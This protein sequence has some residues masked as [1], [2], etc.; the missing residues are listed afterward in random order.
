MRYFGA[1]ILAICLNGF[2]GQPAHA[3]KRVALVI[4]NANYQNVG[5]LANSA[6]DAATLAAT[7]K[8]A[9]FDVVTLRTDLTATEMRR[10]LR[11]F[12]DKARDSDIAVIYYAGH[13][14][15]VDGMNYLIP[16]DA[17]L[18]R[19]TDVYDEAFPLDRLLVAIEPAKHLRLVIL[20]ACRDNPFA[21]TMKRT[22]AMRSI[23]QGL[24]KVE[25]NSPNTLIA[26]AAK[27]GSTA[28]DGDS[29]NNGP[30]AVA[31]SNHLTTPGLDVRKAFGFVRDDVLKATSN[32]QE[33]FIYGSLGG[34]DVPL[35]PAPV[36]PAASPPSA[37]DVNEAI[38]RDYVLAERVGT[39][40]AWDLFLATYPDGFYSKLAQAQRNKLD[41]EDKARAATGE[42]A[43]LAADGAHIAEQAKAAVEAK[44]AEEARV[45]AEQTKA[46]EEARVAE[47]ERANAAAQAKAAEEAKIAA[48][49]A[50]KAQDKEAEE[51][52]A[53]DRVAAEKAAAQA[54]AAEEARLAAEKATQERIAKAQKEAAAAAAKAK[55]AEEARL[56]EE[57][58]VAE[59][60]KAIEA[61]KAAEAE[62]AKAAE[63]KEAEAKAATDK[64]HED[65]PVGQ[66]AAL[67][68]GERLDSATPGA[69]DTPRLLLAE[70]RRVGCFTGS[71]DGTWNE[72]AQRSLELFN[73]HAGT[74]LNTKVASL[75][76]LDVL[77]H[78]NGRV[79]PLI[80]EYGYRPDGDT[81]TR[82][83]CKAGLELG[84]DNTCQ[85]AKPKKPEAKREGEPETLRARPLAPQ[86]NDVGNPE[87]RRCGATSCSQAL[88]GCMRK[89]AIAGG[90]N[91]KCVAK[92]QACLQ[93]GEFSGRFCQHSGL[94]RN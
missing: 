17:I 92:Y 1:L 36:A 10:L 25:P 9:R 50:K 29:G 67:T 18:E 43:R 15:E 20:D 75:D 87:L 54:K 76:A 39:R 74:T 63:A 52:A 26:F 41:A 58:R 94:A 84:D 53:R 93:T 4:G 89:N 90:D 85:R 40:E 61:A 14:I 72:A 44:A 5:H 2:L 88:R 48:A 47:A 8:N 27:A 59:L 83:I 82:I 19:D 3:E 79:C 51:K 16:V 81:C 28:S 21:K 33:P 69:D 35:V 56:A 70:L 24:A 65:K 80:C 34:D 71:L 11:D 37:V 62:H 23:G 32:R 22:V 86:G 46:Q 55:A 13:G 45:V 91:S 38:R 42:R 73:K 66:L 7:F 60:Q 12:G 78:R 49:K 31:L 6:T 64:A 77:Q 57:A 68:P 30:Y